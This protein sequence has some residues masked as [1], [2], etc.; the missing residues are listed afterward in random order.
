[1]DRPDLAE[2][3]SRARTLADAVDEFR[4]AIDEAYTAA[5]GEHDSETD[6]PIVEPSGD[7]P[8]LYEQATK[9]AGNA[10]FELSQI[11]EIL[12]TQQ[13]YRHFEDAGVET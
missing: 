4:E 2:M 6:E 7:D 5:L 9:R 12:A 3:A 13:G 11:L 10:R 1:M 8:E